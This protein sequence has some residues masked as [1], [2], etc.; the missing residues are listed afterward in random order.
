MYVWNR[1]L[2]SQRWGFSITDHRRIQGATGPGHSFLS[3][4]IHVL[5]ETCFQFRPCH[6]SSYYVWSYSLR[7]TTRYVLIFLKTNSF[8]IRFFSLPPFFF[9]EISESASARYPGYICCITIKHI[10]YHKM[11]QYF[12]FFGLTIFKNVFLFLKMWFPVHV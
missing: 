7:F 5:L 6:F 2:E 11:Y 3:L 9:I 1:Y 4:A 10:V 12:M 8:E